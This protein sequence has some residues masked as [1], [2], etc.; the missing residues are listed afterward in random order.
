MTAFILTLGALVI[1][2]TASKATPRKWVAL[3]ALC[4]LLLAGCSAGGSDS[5]YNDTPSAAQPTAKAVPLPTAVPTLHPSS[6]HA[7]SASMMAGDDY[8]IS[9]AVSLGSCVL[10]PFAFF[11]FAY[12]IGGPILRRYGLLPIRGP[13]HE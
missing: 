2:V 5:Y 7:D 3:L 1:L 11:L 9:A 8:F 10:S 13:Q 12:A 4:V 6:K